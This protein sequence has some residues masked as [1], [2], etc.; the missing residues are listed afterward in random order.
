MGL[1]ECVAAFTKRPL[2]P[3]T[4]GDIGYEPDEVEK[5][6]D[7]HFSLAHKWGCVMLL[8][9]ADVFLTKRSVSRPPYTGYDAISNHS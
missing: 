5:N 9:E 6:L 8:D 3:I 7:K 4:C 2:F 1:L